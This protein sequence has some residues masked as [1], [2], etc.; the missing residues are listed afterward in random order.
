LGS[1]LASF[2]SPDHWLPVIG[3]WE[4]LPPL[5]SP[6]SRYRASPDR[7]SEGA[8]VVCFA[9]YQ[10][11]WTITLSMDSLMPSQNKNARAIDADSAPSKPHSSFV[12]SRFCR[13][14]DIPSLMA[15]GKS[16]MTLSFQVV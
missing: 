6:A 5:N 11:S 1:D 7:A 13:D 15:P 8:G 2:P 16:A 14:A 10:V 4:A 12:G 9:K 3:H